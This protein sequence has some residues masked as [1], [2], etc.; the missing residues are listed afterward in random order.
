MKV[1][2]LGG[3]G[4]I[5]HY[6]SQ[7]FREEDAQVYV[8]SRSHHDD[9]S[10]THYIKGNAKEN[11]FLA[12]VCKMQ[13][14]DTIVDFMSYKTEEFAARVDLLLS[15]TRQYVFISSARVYGNEEH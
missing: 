6:L 9:W 1:L 12:N 5:G 7:R 8:T 11:V 3:T 13:T 14:W 2:L 10:N 4:V 15:S